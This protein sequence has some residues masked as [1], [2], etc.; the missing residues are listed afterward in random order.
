M[1]SA[2]SR[3]SGAF[4]PLWVLLCLC[5]S[6]S[7][8]VDIF[9]PL[10]V[11]TISEAVAIAVD[12]DQIIVSPGTWNEA[13]D[14][15]GK[16]IEIRSEAG[17]ELTFIEGTLDASVIRFI[18]GETDLA[19]LEGF[20]I[21]GG[22]GMA[23]NGVRRGGGI[24]ILDSSPRITN[25][26]VEANQAS[27]GG[28]IAIDGG[29]SIS[30]VFDEVVIR[31]NLSLDAG[32]GFA[33]AN[34]IGGVVVQNCTLQGNH[35]NIVAGGLYVEN[36][37]IEVQ[38]CLIDGNSSDL[39][40]GGMWIYYL[41]D[42]IIEQSQIS[43]NTTTISGGGIIVSDF[44]RVTLD[45]C[46]VRNNNG[47]TNGGGL[48]I[49]SGDPSD[50][51]EIRFCVFSGNI[52]MA[53]G[54]NIGVSVNDINLSMERCT[55]G[56]PGANSPMNITV[57]NSNPGVVMMDS[58]I[59]W[60]GSVTPLEVDAGSTIAT[61]SCIEG[62]DTSNVVFTDCIDE[63]PLFI[64]AAAGDFTLGP[65]SSC[66]DT[67][68]PQ[69]P[70]DPDGSPPD[71]GALGPAEGEYFRRG[72][73]DASSTS[74]LADAVLLLSML[75]IP[76]ATPIYCDDAGD[77]DDSGSINLTDPVNIL[78]ALFVTGAPLPPPFSECG[79]DPTADSLG[80]QLSCP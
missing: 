5:S 17:P 38:S 53:S 32:G 54:G 7:L 49:D 80:C 79:A 70:A 23:I 30:V 58:C 69:L 74:N 47:G 52:G 76:G 12:G 39:L 20:T 72:D 4:Y 37:T 35:A 65:T 2:N 11:P 73:V 13:I 50:L 59:V 18:N 9:V 15:A 34:S 68:N 57:N 16:L 31:D 60:G 62:L 55:F 24:Y 22:G 21:R 36:S 19:R 41:S 45:H 33:V 63:D 6:E 25:C 28:G 51:Q 40:A 46:V 71:M 77:A 42:A 67:G 3:R 10:D 75:F 27:A 66:I 26:I 1:F 44:S 61:Y 29:N 78:S 14:F 48:L 56:P 64:D 8:A 43:E